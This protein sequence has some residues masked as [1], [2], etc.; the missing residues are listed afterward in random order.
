MAVLRSFLCSL[1]PRV[2]G[3]KA[4]SLHEAAS[5]L[6]DNYA[7]ITASKLC[8]LRSSSLEL[9]GS[10]EADILWR[11][12][13]LPA[14]ALGLRLGR[15]KKQVKVILACLTEGEYGFSDEV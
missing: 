3:F 13:V 7:A 4:A 9:R 14:L 1:R 15:V 10:K 8:M 5:F 12:V 2:D 11:T 6:L